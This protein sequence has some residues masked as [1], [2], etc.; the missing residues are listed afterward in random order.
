M[1]LAVFLCM[2]AGLAVAA[3]PDCTDSWWASCQDYNR[4]APHSNS[5]VGFGGARTYDYV[6]QE[7]GIYDTFYTELE[8]I[9]CRACHGN[10]L[11]NRHHFSDIVIEFGQCTPCHDPDPNAPGGVV[12]TRDCTTAGCHSVADLG[13]NGWHHNTDMSQG[14]ACVVCHDGNLISEIGTFRDFQLY[15]PTVVTPTPYSCEN[16]HWYQEVVPAVGG[17]VPLPII[18]ISN[19]AS[20]QVQI[21]AHGYVATDEIVL[22]GLTGAWAGLNGTQAIV[23]GAI[24]A[25][26]FFINVDTSTLGGYPGGAQAMLVQSGGN[27][28]AGHPSDFNHLDYWG[29]NIGYF[30]YGKE[31]GLNPHN[32][33]M[34]FLSNITAGGCYKCHGMD[35][36]QTGWT[37]TNPE[38]IRYCEICHD[39][40]S[41]HTIYGHVGYDSQGHISYPGAGYPQDA[42]GWVAT[43]FHVSGEAGQDTPFDYTTFNNNG[44]PSP[45][46]PDEL[47]LGCHVDQLGAPPVPPDCSPAAFTPSIEDVE[48]QLGTCEDIVT[49]RG[50]NFGDEEL[51]LSKVVLVA[52]GP[53]EYQLPVITDWTDTLLKVRIPCFLLPVDGNYGLRVYNLCGNGSNYVTFSYGSWV[54]LQS[55][56]P[57]AT[58]PTLS[59]Q[60]W[61]TLTGANFQDTTLLGSGQEQGWTGNDAQGNPVAYGVHR[62]VEFVSSQFPYGPSPTCP[63]CGPLVGT[64]YQNWAA[65]SVEVLFSDFYVDSYETEAM[66]PDNTWDEEPENHR[67]HMNDGAPTEQQIVGI[68]GIAMGSFEVYF[69]STYYRDNDTSGTLSSPDTI[70]QIV[71]SD[72]EP[73]ELTSFPWINAIRPRHQEPSIPTGVPMAWLNAQLGYVCP[74]CI[75]TERSGQIRIYGNYFGPAQ[76]TG[77]MVRIGDP[78]DGAPSVLNYDMD[79]NKYTADCYPG[80]PSYNAIAC[81]TPPGPA[82]GP[83]GNG[84]ELRVGFWSNDMIGAYLYPMPGEPLLALFGPGVGLNWLDS[85]LGVWVVKDNCGAPY[86]SNIMPMKVLTP[87]P[88]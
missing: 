67:N 44:S 86:P 35:P 10:S 33:M 9:D 64:T 16:C 2:T 76:M 69:V 45:T 78:R 32:H 18:N 38:L 51:S 61:I 7:L 40:Y 13:T 25:N 55:L 50:Y 60:P 41:L 37:H 68:N 52:P 84:V 27:P 39:M 82:T 87:L 36:N 54:S 21:T 53:V 66:F 15:P 63:D 14:N 20:A 81:A 65:G 70:F 72:P 47:C 75:I 12:V 73:F 5:D 74:A 11:A 71:T 59:V 4:P 19:A 80:V 79:G 26:T 34:E 42:Q 88:D 6:A 31:I 43:G 57:C 3:I 77:D 83:I 17:E 29:N 49:I 56:S 24:T 1:M 48:P 8:E 28:I 85:W 30:E 22:Y 62:T 46:G 23:G 58:D